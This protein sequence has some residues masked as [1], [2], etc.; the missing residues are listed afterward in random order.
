[1]GSRADV[2]ELL[3]RAKDAAEECACLEEFYKIEGALTSF[4]HPRRPDVINDIKK[5]LLMILEELDAREEIV[6]IMRLWGNDEMSDDEV[7]DKFYE[8]L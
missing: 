3:K 1:M 8:I 4:M 6:E 5:Q 2:I 7:F